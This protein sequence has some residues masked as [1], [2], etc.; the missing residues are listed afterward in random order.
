MKRTKVVI[1]IDKKASPEFICQSSAIMRQKQFLI[2]KKLAFDRRELDGYTLSPLSEKQDSFEVTGA[3][4]G[5]VTTLH[6]GSDAN[7]EASR[8]GDES[9][10]S[11]THMTNMRNVNTPG[12]I[13][14]NSK[15]C[16]RNN[17]QISNNEPD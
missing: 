1:A 9:P 6:F 14:A 12:T 16:L 11:I 15:S 17:V 13:Y 8:I 5:E 3:F 10:F 2:N 7:H 4:Q